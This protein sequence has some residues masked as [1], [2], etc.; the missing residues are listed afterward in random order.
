MPK[1]LAAVVLAAGQGKRMRAPVPKVLVQACGRSMVEWVLEALRP[2]EPRTTVVVY[3]HGGDAVKEALRGRD[4]AFAHQPEQRGTGHAVQCA[5][6]ALKGFDGDVLVLCGDTPLLTTEVL[7][8][9]VDD[10]RA[11]KRDLTVLSAELTDPGSLGR[12]L[13]GPGGGLREIR[14]AADASPKEREVREIN[15]GVI[16]VDYGLL[17]VAL[18]RLTPDNTQGEYYLTDV[19]KLLLRDGKA[20]DARMTRDETS[21]LGVNRPHDISEALRVVRGRGFRWLLAE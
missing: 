19:P 11:A 2:L 20:V 18:G 9:L 4:L 17:E 10:H 13:R 15:T 1:P 3:G 5:L 7:K 21:A 8:E 16:L 6:P 12:I 14:E